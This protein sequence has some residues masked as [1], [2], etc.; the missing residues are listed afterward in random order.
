MTKGILFQ[1]SS[2][3]IVFVQGQGENKVEMFT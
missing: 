3:E 2:G 1:G